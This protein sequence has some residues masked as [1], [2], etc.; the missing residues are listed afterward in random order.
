MRDSKRPVVYQ[1]MRAPFSA[2]T[3]EISS[4]ALESGSVYGVEPVSDG[5][6]M[7]YVQ[8]TLVR[9]ESV[10]P[11]ANRDAGAGGFIRVRFT[12]A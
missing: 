5:T 6:S 12:A 2:Q 7:H 1:V 8:L 10:D 9:V 11:V 3:A 4:L